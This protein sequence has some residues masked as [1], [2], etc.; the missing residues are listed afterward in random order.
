MVLNLV[1]YIFKYLSDFMQF[2]IAV[3][4]T[5]LPLLSF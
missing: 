1:I 5:L 2:E 3:P 4:L